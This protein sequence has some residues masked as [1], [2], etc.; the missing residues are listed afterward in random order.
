MATSPPYQINVDVRRAH[1]IG[2]CSE[3]GPGT[4]VTILSLTGERRRYSTRAIRESDCPTWEEAVGPIDGSDVGSDALRVQLVL[5]RDGPEKVIGAT[6]FLLR[7]LMLGIAQ[8][9]E[10]GLY[11]ADE[12][13]GMPLDGS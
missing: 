10:Y 8:E 3:G 1:E 13:R 12:E 7:N 4:I 5:R 6:E 2:Q 9:D 11:P